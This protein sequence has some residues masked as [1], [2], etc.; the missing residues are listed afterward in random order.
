MLRDRGE[1]G[2]ES[3]NGKVLVSIEVLKERGNVGDEIIFT[4]DTGN[5][6]RLYH[7]QNCCENVEINDICGDINDLLNTPILLAEEVT[8]HNEIPD[9]VN[10]PEYYESFT[11]TF[12]KIGTVK[13]SVTIRWY[14]GSNGY[15]SER[16]NFE[17][18][19]KAI[20]G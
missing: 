12:Y 8:N 7:E 5:R 16:V 19:G 3:L 20:D 11:W 10:M 1:V 15:Y 6:Y 9:G 13:G 14:G 17:K 4:T 2:F 18:I